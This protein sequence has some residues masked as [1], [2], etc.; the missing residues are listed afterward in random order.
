M[1]FTFRNKRIS[2]PRINDF[3]LECQKYNRVVADFDFISGQMFTVIN[4][5]LATLHELQTIY[6]YEDMLI[7]YDVCQIASYNEYA[8]N[9]KASELNK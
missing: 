9:K 3:R 8:V 6:C 2:Y 4:S 1:D 5:K 7:L